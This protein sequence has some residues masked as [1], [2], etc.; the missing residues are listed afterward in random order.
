MPPGRVASRHHWK[1]SVLAERL[2]RD[3]DAAA[4]GEAL[5][6]G[7]RVLLREVDHLV[8]AHLAREVQAL[9]DRVDAD[10]QRGALQPRA[11]GG[12][13]PDRALG[14]DGD[15]LADLHVRGLGGRD[16]GG[17]DVCQQHALLIA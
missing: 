6:G 11:G 15:G 17:G 5:D 10:D 16:A 4:A 2:D 1:V 7:D 8:G 9:L 14:E 3:V 12:A 13:E